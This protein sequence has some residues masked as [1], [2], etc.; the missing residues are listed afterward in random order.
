MSLLILEL[1]E[2]VVSKPILAS[3][4]R[5]R[6]KKLSIRLVATDGSEVPFDETILKLCKYVHDKLSQDSNN[7]L[8]NQVFPLMAQALGE[9]LSDIVGREM[10]EMLLSFEGFRAPCLSMMMLSFTLLKFLQQKE[11]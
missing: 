8:A 1:N 7:T 2:V 6:K 9:G 10:T 3:I 11:I 5:V 4:D